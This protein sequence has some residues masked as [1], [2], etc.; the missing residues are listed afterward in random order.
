MLFFAATSWC[1]SCSKLDH[2]LIENISNIP[3]DTTVLKVDFDNDQAMNNKYSVTAQ[4]TL[5]VLD[6]QGNELKRWLGGGFE[7][8]L[9]ETQTI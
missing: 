4:H 7:Q 1:Q 3:S 8:F 6:S 9:Q 2:E 5:V